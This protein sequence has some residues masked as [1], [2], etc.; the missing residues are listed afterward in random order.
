MSET[1]TLTLGVSTDDPITNYGF[2]LYDEG[3][4]GYPGAPFGA[5]SPGTLATFDVV[6]LA[7]GPSGDGFA[8]YLYLTDAGSAP[9]SETFETLEFTDDA[10][11]VWVFARADANDP[12][13]ADFTFGPGD[14]RAWSWTV[15]ASALPV[16]TPSSEYEV[17]VDAPPDSSS[18]GE[19]LPEPVVLFAVAREPSS[20]VVPR[21]RT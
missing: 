2:S 10:D 15:S 16:V 8:F 19:T 3:V 17:L 7:F 1:L 5:V 12:E 11:A 14:V 21:E 13:G 20:F 4:T 6:Y 9:P 18:T